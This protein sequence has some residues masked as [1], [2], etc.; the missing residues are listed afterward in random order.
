MT[1]WLVFQA[2][3]AMAQVQSLVGEPRSRK[4]RGTAKI[5]KQNVLDEFLIEQAFIEL[6]V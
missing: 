4:P 2:F 1:E 6:L 3:T 5:N